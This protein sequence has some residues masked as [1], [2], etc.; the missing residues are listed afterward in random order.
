MRWLTAGWNHHILS[1]MLAHFFLWHLKVK[2]GKKSSCPYYL[3]AQ[4][5][6]ENGITTANL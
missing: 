1:C 2:L 4:N 6:V 3:A 5:P